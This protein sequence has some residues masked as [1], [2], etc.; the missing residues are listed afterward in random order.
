MVILDVTT[1]RYETLT[2]S[3]TLATVSPMSAGLSTIVTGTLLQRTDFEMAVPLL[4]EM[5]ARHDPYACRGGAVLPAIKPI[6]GFCNFLLYNFCGFLLCA[7]PISPI[8]TI[9]RVSLSSWNSLG[10]STKSSTYNGIA[11]NSNA[12]IVQVLVALA[13]RRLH[14]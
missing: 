5:I 3:I 9:A 4:P 8:N 12:W 7:S 13:A 10:M 1:L 11:P 2:C 6:T 14:R